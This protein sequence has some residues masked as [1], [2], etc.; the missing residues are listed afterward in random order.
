MNKT[1]LDTYSLRI[2]STNKNVSITPIVD[3]IE[4]EHKENY[5]IKSCP[6]SINSFLVKSMVL[7]MFL[8]FY[9][10]KL[11]NIAHIFSKSI[12][13]TSITYGRIRTNIDE[14]N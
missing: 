6:L 8:S 1:N 3:I 11:L 10:M 12:S 5:E 14:N 2:N 7:F 13:A 9:I 4:G